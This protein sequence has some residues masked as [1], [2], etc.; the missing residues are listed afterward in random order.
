MH[1][2]TNKRHNVHQPSGDITRPSSDPARSYA[3]PGDLREQFAVAESMHVW[4][5]TRPRS[6]PRSLYRLCCTSR[7]PSRRARFRSPC[8]GHPARCRSRPH[9]P[10]RASYRGPSTASSPTAAAPPS[11]PSVRASHGPPPP[12]PSVRWW[13]DDVW[14]SSTDATTDWNQE[15]AP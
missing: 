6:R 4:L 11:T 13:A 14:G 15:V 7:R 9:S 10:P 1:L 8:T 12:V 3:A 2:K 5:S